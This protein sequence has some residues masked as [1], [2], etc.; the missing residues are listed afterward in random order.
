M[1]FFRR[2]AW[3]LAVS[4]LF[5]CQT[6]DQEESSASRTER[7]DEV[8][9][10]VV[11]NSARKAWARGD[12]SAAAAQF[13]KLYAVKPD[14]R[15]VVIEYLRSLR[16]I[17]AIRDAYRISR[18]TYDAHAEDLSY[19]LAVARVEL[20]MGK[21]EEALTSLQ[22]ARELEPRS[23][24][25]YSLLGVA[26]D[27]REEFERAI[28][29]YRSALELSPGNEVVLNNMALSTAQ[30]GDIDGAIA[31]LRPLIA[32]NRSSS[33]RIRQNLA[34]LYGFKG[35]LKELE[36]LGRMDLNEE[37]VRRNLDAFR[38]AHEKGKTR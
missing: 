22:R 1:S 32:T 4:G 17:G 12:H 24:E 7:A 26:H 14:D 21:A 5:G 25:V 34:I 13:G 27:S 31:L 38:A 30:A 36:A 16:A 11:R 19:L 18:D 28:E 20:A 23:W 3:I 8:V 6:P 33:A 9:A 2:W 29:S 35:N 10:E 37:M 15:E